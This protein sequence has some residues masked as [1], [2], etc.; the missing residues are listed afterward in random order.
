MC[1]K[2]ERIALMRMDEEDDFY[3]D[4]DDGDLDYDEGCA[5]YWVDGEGWH[6][7]LIGSEECDWECRNPPWE[8]EAA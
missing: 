1:G 5:A 2:G 7:P 3:D 4:T 8:D 6:C